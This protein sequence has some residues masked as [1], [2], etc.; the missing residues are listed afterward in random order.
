MAGGDGMGLHSPSVA[1]GQVVTGARC[2][3]TQGPWALS[4][5]VGYE[6]GMCPACRGWGGAVGCC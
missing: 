3:Q 2:S 5:G 4:V 1:A 6:T